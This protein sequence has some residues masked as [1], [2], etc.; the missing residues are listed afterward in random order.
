MPPTRIELVTLGYFGLR[1]RRIV[2]AE[3]VILIKQYR[4][5]KNCSKSGRAL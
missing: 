2:G 3:I 5:I 1:A 4:K